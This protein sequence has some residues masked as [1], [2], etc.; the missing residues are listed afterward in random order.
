MAMQRLRALGQN[1]RKWSEDREK[2]KSLRRWLTLQR[3]VW[4]V[5]SRVGG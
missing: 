2:V 5:H 4:R 3:N 1:S